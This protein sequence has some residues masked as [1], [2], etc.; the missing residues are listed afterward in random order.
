MSLNRSLTELQL[1]IMHVLWEREEATVAEVVESLRTEKELA[2]TTVATILSRLEK[3]GYVA[4]RKLGSSHF[5]Y[6]IVKR[7]SVERSMVARLVDSLYG[8]DVTELV[9]CL[10][11]ESDYDSDEI[12]RAVEMINEHEGGPDDQ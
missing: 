5:Y 4:H 6:S 1:A 8:G 9:N 12:R 7:K 2:R 3:A 10:L 11:T